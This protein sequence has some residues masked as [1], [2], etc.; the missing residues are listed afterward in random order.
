VT[1]NPAD[2]GANVNL[3]AGNLV[4][5]GASGASNLVR[6]TLGQSTGKYYFEVVRTLNNSGG[7]NVGIAD[8]A[9]ALNSPMGFG[10]PGNYAAWAAT[11]QSFCNGAFV[12]MVVT[13]AQGDVYNIAI[14]FTA[15]KLWFGKNG[16]YVNS[17][18][19]SAGTGET[20]VLQTG[21]TYYPIIGCGGVSVGTARFASAS[22]GFAAPSGFGPWGGAGARAFSEAFAE[23]FA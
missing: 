8:A 22:W 19:P 11:N 10:S 18:N 9:L 1:W 15:H 5:T 7:P 17:G 6:A 21:V 23:G 14:D 12:G 20:W 4:A 3:S 16:V 2:K 13:M